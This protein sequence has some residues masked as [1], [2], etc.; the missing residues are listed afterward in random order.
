MTTASVPPAKAEIRNLSFSFGRTEALKSVSMPIADR[1][2]TALIGPSGCGKTTFL[3][4]LNRMQDLHPDVRYTGEIILH[5]EQI[6]IIDPAIDPI[7]VRMRVGMVFQKPNPFPKSI[8]ENVVYGL[9][10][11][12]IRD[13]ATLEIDRRHRG[14]GRELTNRFGHERRREGLDAGG[15]PIAAAYPHAGLAGKDP[16]NERERSKRF[17]H[18]G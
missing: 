8:F 1:R 9:R 15:N 10:I 3:R 2:V 4:C 14:P 6:N 11:R 7:E 18:A 13:R 17:V 5:P 16:I 12:G